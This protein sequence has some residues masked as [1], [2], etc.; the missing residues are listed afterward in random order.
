[1]RDDN[2][3][4]RPVR[5]DLFCHKEFENWDVLRCDIEKKFNQ[6]KQST[7]KYITLCEYLEDV[8]D[9]NEIELD[10]GVKKILDQI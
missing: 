8:A 9:K 4:H 3:N 7:L 5:I 6:S 2:H 10:Y 1:M